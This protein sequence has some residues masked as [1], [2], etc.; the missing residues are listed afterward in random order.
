[1]FPTSQPLPGFHPRAEKLL[2]FKA[3]PHPPTRPEPRRA[4][5]LGRLAVG[6]FF[7]S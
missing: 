6:V 5:G 7:L 1:M 4:A 2:A 3:S